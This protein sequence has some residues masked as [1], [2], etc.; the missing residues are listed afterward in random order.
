MPIPECQSRSSPP[1][2]LASSL[3]TEIS[4]SKV[5][6]IA[7]TRPYVLPTVNFHRMTAMYCLYLHTP[8]T[9]LELKMVPFPVSKNVV[10]S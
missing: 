5:L 10:N 1:P 8:L 9:I 4:Q 6:D 2:N 3:S 7:F